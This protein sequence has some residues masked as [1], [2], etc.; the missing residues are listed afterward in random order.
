MAVVCRLGGQREKAAEVVA[1]VWWRGKLGPPLQRKIRTVPDLHLRHRPRR[2][3]RG[4]A[5]AGAGAAPRRPRRGPARRP[6][7]TDP[8]RR[9]R[10]AGGAFTVIELVVVVAIVGVL[11]GLV[12][13]ALHR[14]RE[15]ASRLQ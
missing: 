12:L 4:P 11:S 5:A 8:R 14:A 1:R 9:T 2:G 3:R 6:G 10:A 7:M 13:S 15:L